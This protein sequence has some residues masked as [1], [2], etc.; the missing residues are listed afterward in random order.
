MMSE[1]ERIALITFVVGPAVLAVMNWLLTRRKLDRID[2]NAAITRD[3]VA[4]DHET[5][6]REEN[7]ERHEVNVKV[8]HEI[9]SAIG[10]IR[11]QLR[12]LTEADLILTRRADRQA[13][14]LEELERTNP[15]HQLAPS[16]GRHRKETP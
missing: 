14:K 2:R 13:E 1:S 9:K 7:D 11:D 3:N 6:M 8:L 10:G 15:P 12:H 16:G 5:N 4:N